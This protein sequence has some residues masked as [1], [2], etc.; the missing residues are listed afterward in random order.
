VCEHALASAADAA[1]AWG[2]P[3]DWPLPV[4]RRLAAGPADTGEAFLARAVSAAGR[5]ALVA[6]AAERLRTTWALPGDG[7]A[8]AAAACR[9]LRDLPPPVPPGSQPA[10]GARWAGDEAVVVGLVASQAVRLPLLPACAEAPALLLHHACSLPGYACLPP[11]SV[12]CLTTPCHRSEPLPE[13]LCAALAA[14][15]AACAAAA[16]ALAD[17]VAGGLAS[18]EPLAAAAACAARAAW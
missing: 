13:T 4:L 11:R 9:A 8:L 17:A 16:C 14:D 6:A 1:A 18:V 3:V 5:L 10:P 12:V 2:L 7:A 15:P